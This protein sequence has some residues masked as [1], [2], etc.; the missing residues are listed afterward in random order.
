MY[1]QGWKGCTTYRKAS[2]RSS[3]HEAQFE[4]MRSPARGF[5]ASFFGAL[6]LRIDMIGAKRVVEVLRL[7]GLEA[8][9]PR[10]LATTSTGIQYSPRIN[11]TSRE[12]SAV[13]K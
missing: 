10:F 5:H 2:Q 4:T 11:K 3:T 12:R 9:H 6:R 7:I 8:T 1:T 13:K